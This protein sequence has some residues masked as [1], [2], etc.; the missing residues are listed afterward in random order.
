MEVAGGLYRWSAQHKLQHEVTK[1]HEVAKKAFVG[2]ELDLKE[3]PKKLLIFV[4][5]VF[6]C[7]VL[8]C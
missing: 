5:F 4:C 2:D 7:F 6:M 1:S 8:S 3:S